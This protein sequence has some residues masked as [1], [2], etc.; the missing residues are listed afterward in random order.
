[1]V[2]AYDEAYEERL[3]EEVTEIKSALTERV[4][5]YLEYG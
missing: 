1:M 5:S 2:A 4:D 3:V